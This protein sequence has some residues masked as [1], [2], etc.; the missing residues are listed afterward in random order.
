MEAECGLRGYLLM[1]GESGGNTPTEPDM[2]A[3]AGRVDGLAVLPHTIPQDLL[4][5]ISRRIPVVQLSMPQRA[6]GIHGVTVDNVTGMKDL[7]HHMISVHSFTDM[8]FVGPTGSLEKAQRFSAYQEAM[9]K[10]GLPS[11]S[12][13]TRS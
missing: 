2:Y 12:I 5:K 7:I 11:R 9:R 8:V 13:H 1:I 4:Q 3:L 6:P 10:A